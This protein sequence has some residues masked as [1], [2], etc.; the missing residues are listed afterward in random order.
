MRVDNPSHV[1]T[2][3]YKIVSTEYSVIVLPTSGIDSPLYLFFKKDWDNL[4]PYNIHVKMFL[5]AFLHN[6]VFSDC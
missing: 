2:T 1:K 5:L 6:K 4:F 3:L